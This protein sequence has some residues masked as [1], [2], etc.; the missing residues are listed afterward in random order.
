MIYDSEHH[1]MAIRLLESEGL[2]SVEA[3]HD[4]DFNSV[5]D[6]FIG[7]IPVGLK[8]RGKN[9]GNDFNL[10]VWSEKKKYLPE[11]ANAGGKLYLYWTIYGH[12]LLEFLD[13]ELLNELLPYEFTPIRDGRK[14]KWINRYCGVRD[15]SEASDTQQGVCYVPETLTKTRAIWDLNGVKQWIDD[16]WL[17]EMLA[18]SST[19]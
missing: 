2:K 11:F 18:I 13:Q 14:W 12:V 19:M 7:N 8:R 16:D 15:K 4:D 6:R 5:G 1:E 3:S 17:A 9:S 10:T